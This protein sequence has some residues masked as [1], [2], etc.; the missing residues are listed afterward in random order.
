MVDFDLLAPFGSAF[1]FDH[2]DLS[3]GLVSGP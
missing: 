2:V 3:F 1:L